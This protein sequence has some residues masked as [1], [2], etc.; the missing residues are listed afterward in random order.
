MGE[1]FDGLPRGHYGAILA[2]P[3]WA[4]NLW[5]G[6]RTNENA[7]RRSRLAQLNQS[8]RSCESRN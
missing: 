2:D 6:G 3:P 4:F 1:M 5:W 8:I 7:R